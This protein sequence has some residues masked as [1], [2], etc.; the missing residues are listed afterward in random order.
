MS[1]TECVSDRKIL[2]YRDTT[3]QNFEILRCK[4]R[5]L[6]L[7]QI[8]ESSIFFYKMCDF[9]FDLNLAVKTFQINVYFSMRF[10]KK[11]KLVFKAWNLLCVGNFLAFKYVFLVFFSKQCIW[12][13]IFVHQ[14]SWKFAFKTSFSVY[15]IHFYLCGQVEN[16]KWI[17][18]N[19]KIGVKCAYLRFLMYNYNFN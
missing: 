5:I 10:K 4:I 11:K 6:V 19:W 12:L 13:F 8:Q 9:T 1:V 18:C 2:G 3:Y 17:L 16:T 15:N 7:L 14:K